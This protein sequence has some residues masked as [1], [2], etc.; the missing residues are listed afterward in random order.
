[1]NNRLTKKE[2]ADKIFE[3]YYSIPRTDNANADIEYARKVNTAMYVKKSYKEV[4]EAYN[5]ALSLEKR[6]RDLQNESK[7]LEEKYSKVEENKKLMTKVDVKKL[8]AFIEQKIK[9]FTD[10]DNYSQGVKDAS[11]D[12]LSFLKKLEKG[13]TK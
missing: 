6:M 1:M 13:G 4:L 7:A 5:D 8:K 3:V 9:L 2:M 10:K 12:I 11:C